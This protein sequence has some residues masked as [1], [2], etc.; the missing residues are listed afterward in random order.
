[1]AEP[2]AEP[3][4]NALPEHNDQPW[5][6]V[7]S[8]R[9]HGRIAP[10]HSPASIL[11]PLKSA[12]LKPPKQIIDMQTTVDDPAAIYVSR[13]PV[14]AEILAI[15]VAIR[16]PANKENHNIQQIAKEFLSFF[17]AV[18]P[19]TA[20]MPTVASS[21]DLSLNDIGH[22]PDNDPDGRFLAKYLDGIA[23]A[24]NGSLHFRMKIATSKRLR[25]FKRNS[26]F[27]GWLQRARIS[28][29]ENNLGSVPPTNAGFFIHAI[30]SERSEPLF[31]QMLL[32]NDPELAKHRLQ[33][34]ASLLFDNNREGIQQPA[35]KIYRVHTSKASKDA[36][37]NILSTS[38]DSGGNAFV[39]ISQ[40][41]YHRMSHSSKA[42]V[43][44]SQQAWTDDHRSIFVNG[45]KDLTATVVFK[46]KPVM[47]VH[48]LAAMKTNENSSLF[49]ALAGSPSPRN[50]AIELYTLRDNAPTAI[51]WARNAH[52]H[53]AAILG[54][55]VDAATVFSQPPS[56]NRSL[57]QWSATTRKPAFKDPLSG[58]PPS[59]VEF[60]V[61]ASRSKTSM[62]T[63]QHKRHKVI[64]INYLN[65]DQTA[66]LAV[67]RA[68]QASTESTFANEDSSHRSGETRSYLSAASNQQG[69]VRS[70]H[71]ALS[72]ESQISNLTA[73]HNK[74]M[75][76]LRAHVRA[77]DAKYQNAVTKLEQ[78]AELLQHTLQVSRPVSLEG[79]TISP[80]AASSAGTAKSVTFD[81]ASTPEGNSTVM[82]VL[83]TS[84]TLRAAVQASKGSRGQ[85]GPRVGR[86]F[87][88]GRSRVDY[89]NKISIDVTPSP[90]T[91][92][93]IPRTRNIQDL[94][95]ARGPR[96][97]G[98]NKRTLPDNEDMETEESQSLRD[99]PTPVESMDYNIDNTS[100]IKS[101]TEQG[102][103][104]G[105]TDLGRQQP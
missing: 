12:L 15:R 14:G 21:G 25:V 31:H 60:P 98:H 87:G 96:S 80:T 2:N 19:D 78:F 20:I 41:T 97:E 77:T 52:A 26:F 6:Q 33:I 100:T 56:V 103:V 64:G 24:R 8:P 1:M 95:G 72:F 37:C 104:Y 57:D 7:G 36:V 44:A 54:M 16:P 9:S 84:S 81:A 92:T 91:Q 58:K 67:E 35:V 83:P 39:F 3:D 71:T 13:D 85:H 38:Y 94:M 46:D 5:T 61:Y 43:H 4:A 53:I 62:P 75:A 32:D 47:L 86:A 45:I 40:D 42:N 48:Y 68:E 93:S 101:L 34:N 51:E 89:T 82:L 49:V 50:P 79:A 59:I 74:E 11:T 70:T 65:E 29:V 55:S 90:P 30:P 18:A 28:L 10:N 23:V 73:K 99:Q 105:H 102:D 66:T 88:N 27:M 22:F 69:S 76:S 17:Q 63:K